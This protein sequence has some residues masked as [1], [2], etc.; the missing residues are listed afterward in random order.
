MIYFVLQAH[1]MAR[2]N[3]LRATPPEVRDRLMTRIE[4]NKIQFAG[5]NSFLAL[6]NKLPSHQTVKGS[7]DVQLARYSANSYAKRVELIS[8]LNAAFKRHFRSLQ[9][10]VLHM[11]PAHCIT[12]QASINGRNWPVGTF[13]E[14]KWYIY[15]SICFTF[16]TQFIIICITYA[17]PT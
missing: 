10:K 11:N 15:V 9:T 8:G 17:H 6:G 12:S 4:K 5:L 3:L 2:G 13:C 1:A 7:G 14:Y 16:S